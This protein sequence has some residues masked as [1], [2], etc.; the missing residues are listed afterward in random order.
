MRVKFVYEGY[1]VE[2]KVTEARK[3]DNPYSCKTSIG[4]R[5]NSG[6]IKHISLC[7]SRGYR[8]RRI[9]WCDRRLC[10]VTGS[11]HA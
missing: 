10:H 4:N 5:P 11:D 1:Q 6:S 9:E 2:V 3:V 7:V 8:L